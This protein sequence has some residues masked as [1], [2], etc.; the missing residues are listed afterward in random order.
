MMNLPIVTTAIVI[1]ARNE[2]RRISDCLQALKPQLDA[3]CMIVLVANNCTDG[4]IRAARNALCGPQL[5]VLECALAPEQGV[6]AARRMGFEVA[7]RAAPDLRA[8]LTTDADC[9]AAPDWIAANLRHLRA[10]DAVCGAVTP[11]EE[12]R[13]ILRNM[14]ANEGQNEAAYRALVQKFYALVYPEPHNPL[15]HHGEAPGASLAVSLQAYHAVGGFA[16]RRTGEDRD[17][18][19]RIRQAGLLVRH[20]SN[21]CVAASCRL[22][23]RA[24]GG[25]AQALRDRLAGTDYRIDD[26]LPPTAWL[27]DHMRC[28][29]LP[30]WPPELPEALRLRSRDLPAQIASLNALLATMS[31]GSG[32]RS[33]DGVDN[34]K[35]AFTVEK[36]RL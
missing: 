21:V 24:P 31:C 25:M 7:M 3:L 28:G 18:V 26:G 15:P 20:A 5:L 12:E 17:L 33:E 35:L 8:L 13:D 34:M 2:E 14:S 27:L 1:P 9:V 32:A 29:T 16:D 22:T 23:G 6:G 10:F 30:M 11:M 36:P 4:T 19:R